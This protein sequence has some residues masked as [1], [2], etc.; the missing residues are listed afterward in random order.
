MTDALE[1]LPAVDLALLYP[2]GPL[3]VA[4]VVLHPG[5]R[6]DPADLAGALAPVPGPSWPAA[7]RVVP[8]VATTAWHR[9]L[10]H[11]LVEEGLP[12][13]TAGSPA[14]ARNAAG[15]GYVRLDRAA[16]RRLAARAA[17]AAAPDPAAAPSSADPAA[18]PP[19][20]TSD[21]RPAGPP[22]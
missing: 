19:G 17:R 18:S 22:R 15:T 12:P 3:A 16:L 1:R 10:V 8:G 5:A 2:V 9:P 14:W 20:P 11:P 4:A 13:A 6:L 21:A 7:V